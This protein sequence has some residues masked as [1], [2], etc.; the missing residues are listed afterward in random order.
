MALSSSASA[1]AFP[2]SLILARGPRRGR[3][4]VA[5]AAVARSFAAPLGTLLSRPLAVGALLLTLGAFLFTWLK[6]SLYTPSRVYEDLERESGGLNSVS[7]EYDAWTSEGILEYYWG[8]HIHL[9]YYPEGQRKAPFYG[10][11]NFIEAKYDFIDK[12]LECVRPPALMA[13]S[14]PIILR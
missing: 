9:G 12:M 5:S 11:K 4:P 10:G 13:C 8:E 7:R 14:F 6:R 1:A 3:E 2:H